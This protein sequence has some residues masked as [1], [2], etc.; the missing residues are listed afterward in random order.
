MNNS[1]IH[2][3]GLGNLGTAFFEGLYSF[4]DESSIVLYDESEDRINFFQSNFELSV[5]QKL[6]KLQQEF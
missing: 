1:D 2:I 6:K 4:I 5:K 3:I